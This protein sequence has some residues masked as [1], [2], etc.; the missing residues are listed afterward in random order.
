MSITPEQAVAL[1]EKHSSHFNMGTERYGFTAAEVFRFLLDHEQQLIAALVERADSEVGGYKFSAPGISKIDVVAHGG[2][3]KPLYTAESVASLQAKLEAAQAAQPPDTAM[4][5]WLDA[6]GNGAPWVARQS[7]TGRGYRLH[8][9]KDGKHATVREAIADAMRNAE[10]AAP[11]PEICG[12]CQ[13]DGACKRRMVLCNTHPGEYGRPVE[14]KPAPVSQGTGASD[15]RYQ[16]AIAIVRTR[17]MASIS[18]VQLHLQIGYNRAA[19]MIEA[20]EKD[21]IVT[22]WSSTGM[23]REVI[24]VADRKP[25]DD[26]EGG[27]L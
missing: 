7:G 15:P 18:L 19:L 10:T 16:E 1:A 24:P 8:N 2:N 13:P 26:T 21:G 25:A 5:N 14:S 11:G 27:A 6:Q 22:P 20:M 9:D 17:N 4:L 12:H 3:W 23:G